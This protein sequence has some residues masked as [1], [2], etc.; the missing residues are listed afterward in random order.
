MSNG[1]CSG[2]NPNKAFNYIIRSGGLTFEHAYPYMGRRQGSC[3]MSTPIAA[4]INGF[5]HVP[6]YD[7]FALMAAVAVQPVVVAVQAEDVPFK[8]YGGGIFRGPCGTKPDHSVM[9]V[10]YGTTDY[11][12][13]YWIVK[14]SWGPNCGENG[15]IRMKRDV[16][17][18]E[19]LC[20]I[21]MDPS[22]P[23]KH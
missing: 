15:F 13:K 10:G 22:Y 6:Q 20:G 1:G 18:R 14:N 19:G 23:V 17:E 12:E 21:L 11:G 7:T 9:L 3:T 4:T 8:R 5:Q 16:T 2:G